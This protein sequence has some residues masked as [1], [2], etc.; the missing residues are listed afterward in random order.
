MPRARAS[1]PPLRGAN[2]AGRIAAPAT[3]GRALTPDELV[4]VSVRDSFPASD[5]PGYG[6]GRLGAPAPAPAASAKRSAMR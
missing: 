1:T 2:A 5:P 4:D 3:E 6:G